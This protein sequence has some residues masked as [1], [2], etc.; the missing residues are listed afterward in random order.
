MSRLLA[1]SLACAALV[2]CDTGDAQLIQPTDVA[3]LE[4]T[5]NEPNTSVASS[6]PEPTVVVASSTTVRLPENSVARSTAPVAPEGEWAIPTYVVMCESGG[7]W[8]AYNPSSGAAGPYQLMPSHFGEDARNRSRAE[9]H[10]KAAELWRGG[11]GRHHW[12]ECL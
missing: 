3:R 7:D 10:A 9:Q 4:P 12:E 8:D 5:P 2:S 6:A 1:A 11:T